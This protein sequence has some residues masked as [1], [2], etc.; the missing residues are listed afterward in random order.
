M[1]HSISAHAEC[2]SREK[3]T[4]QRRGEKDPPEPQF[5]I[6]NLS[7]LKVPSKRWKEVELPDRHFAVDSR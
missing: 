4:V 7:D 1:N 3:D 5:T 6:K 2:E